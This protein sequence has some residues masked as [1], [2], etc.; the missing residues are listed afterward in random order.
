M[1][2]LAWTPWHQVVHLRDDL[3][4]GELSLAAF[5]ADLYDVAM[6]QGR[7]RIY[8]D[9]AEFFALTYPTY[10]LRELARD[11][12]QRLAGQNE[13]AVRQ[14][15]LTYGGGKT[16][17]LIT[18]Y[19]LVHD[20]AH[21]PDLPAVQE[22]VQHA[23][24]AP[25]QARVAVLP[26][27]KL[28]VEKGMEVRGPD[29][30]LRWLK[31]PWSVLAFQIAG[32]D[33]L[34][35][36][37]AEDRDAERESAPA[38]NLLV[39]L[40]SIPERQGLATL[41]LVDEV[42]MYAREKIGLAPEWRGRLI[43]FFQ[44]LTQ[45]VTKVDHC[46]LVASLLATDPRKSD[47]LGK[48][49]TQELYAIFRRE[50]EEGV[51]PVLK[52]DV[53]EV[54]R[55]RF[56]TPESLQQ[57]DAFRSH[58]VAALKG[59]AA[60]DEQTAKEGKKAEERFLA[61]YPFH[62]DLTEV[63]Y[64]KWTN[65][66]GFQRT[67]GVLRTFALALRDAER[68]DACPLVG[69]NV[70]LGAPGEA[71][72]PG[73]AGISEAARELTTIAETEEYE[74]KRQEWS[75]I[76]LGELEKARE[77]Q[78]QYPG[79]QH[80]EVEQAV[81]ATF[82]HSQP[83]GHKALTREL[84][85]LLGP[86]RP[87][88][89]ELEKALQQWVQVS[90][91]LDEDVMQGPDGSAPGA[92]AA[93]PRA[94]RLGSRPNLTQM[95]HDA[96]QYRVPPELV[97]VRLIEEIEKLKSLTVGASGPGAR[98]HKLP[99]SPNQIDDDGQFHYV[100]LRP[101]AACDPGQPGELARRFLDEKT[102]PANP[103]VYRNA[104]VLVA[105]SPSGLE[106][107]R[108]SIVSYLGWE[109][110][111]GQL[112][113]QGLGKSDPLRW[114]TL[115]ARLEAGRKAIPGAIRQAY[116]VVVTV[117]ETN[118]VEAFKVTVGSDPLF[119]TI[120]ADPRSR[121]QETAVSA[122]ALLPGGPYELWREGETAR[123]LKDLVGAFAQ[124][125]HLPKMLNQ[126]A[127]L[128]TLVQGCLDGTFVFRLQRPDGSARTFWRYRPE[129]AVLKEPGVE[130][131][132]PEAATL[133]KLASS[134]LAPNELPGLWSGQE[135]TVQDVYDYFGG[136]TVIQVQR[137]GYEEPV[138]VPAAP[139]EVVDE[140][141]EE[142][143]RSGK[144]WLLSGPASVWAEEIPA[145]LLTA[146]AR[147]LPPPKPIPAG[148]LLATAMPEAWSGEITTA[149]AITVAL[150]NRAGEN[151]PWPAVRRALDDAFRVHFLERL[152]DSGPWPCPYPGAQNVKVRVP[153]TPPP[154][155]PPP[156]KPGV[157]VAEARLQTHEIQDLADSLGDLGKVT[158]GYE[159]QF[160][161]RIE[162]GGDPPDDV[163]ERANDVLA[164]VSG[165]LNLR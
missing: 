80:R 29:G 58:V 74:G 105:P 137:E 6:Q 75:A 156:P 76:L 148:D 38:E 94:W 24:M 158:A 4:T 154:P 9:P 96:C 124:H 84:M 41:V 33:G 134:L 40:L 81:F 109:E 83:I 43:N 98:V 161:V 126:Q 59:V 15:E 108:Q 150:S 8:E 22:F 10:N 110:V 119:Q 32:A 3:R 51:Q 44:Y 16:H 13:K 142:A 140:A 89:I 5:A 99:H 78:Q 62:P 152:P 104:V 68:W 34:R 165:E 123:W 63:F 30:E 164:E 113:E 54:L 157:R 48:E 122:E 45:A 37:H 91:F 18:L 65:L 146:G 136:E 120:K 93:L 57:R 149:L 153:G 17:A 159:L 143:V 72:V 133:T 31:Q 97:E 12:V 56:F 85:L 60:L 163:V 151:L 128:D 116:S 79:L 115:L 7:R 55:R 135:I 155:P 23:G 86:S 53:A 107:A 139:K 130:V 112:Q 125:P 106:Q 101:E 92:E 88:R 71:G 70:F 19:H 82:L 64:T 102:G 67:R 2:K 1:T 20:P 87:D 35:L 47:K 144:L 52:E 14:L 95:H 127:I 162:L 42:L 27:D 50:R 111:R 25:P 11:V 131:V 90:W 129:D 26:F 132:L 36:L 141:V 46:A 39:E 69:P 103:R 118:E 147:L 121:I 77:V 21:L 114:Q 49:I 66:E 145:G 73:G 138:F 28:D 160:S 100:I 61:S 117:S